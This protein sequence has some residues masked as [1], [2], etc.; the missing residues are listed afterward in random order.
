LKIPPRR[1]KGKQATPTK[2]VLH[3][4]IKAITI[5]EVIA[6]RASNITAKPSVLAPFRV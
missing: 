6:K 1:K 4:K 2:A 5:P 3:V